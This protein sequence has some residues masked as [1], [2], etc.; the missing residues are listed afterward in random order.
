MKKIQYL[1]L[2]LTTLLFL[3][4]CNTEEY[5]YSEI[6]YKNLEGCY[7]IFAIYSHVPTEKREN[8][9]V[10]VYCQ[11]Q[12]DQINKCKKEPKYWPIPNEV[13]D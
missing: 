2:I 3:S 12:I 11:Y 6:G 4:H 9:D 10:I 13:A 8:K 5:C 7:I 1:F